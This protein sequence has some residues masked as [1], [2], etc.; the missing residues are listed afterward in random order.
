MER[1]KHDDVL[2]TPMRLET[3]STSEANQMTQEPQTLVINWIKTVF[4]EKDAET[5]RSSAN[6]DTTTNAS[7]FSCQSCSLFSISE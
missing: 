6:S 7:S 3:R 4:G 2:G 5:L 1:E